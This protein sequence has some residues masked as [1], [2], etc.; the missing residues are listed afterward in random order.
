[1]HSERQIQKT[2]EC[3]AAKHIQRLQYTG[4]LRFA[5]TEPPRIMFGESTLK[6][7]PSKSFRTVYQTRVY[8]MVATINKLKQTTKKSGP[9]KRPAAT[10]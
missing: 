7:T 6:R 9:D 2:N 1:M 10:R 3:V 5:H 8:W 4:D